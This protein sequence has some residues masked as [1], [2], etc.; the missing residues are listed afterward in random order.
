M[1]VFHYL[2]AD[3]LNV[4]FYLRPL[5]SLYFARKG[6]GAPLAAL[7]PGSNSFPGTPSLHLLIKVHTTVFS[8]I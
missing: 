2:T 1:N 5:H 8:L 7:L 6:E 4:Q 3:N